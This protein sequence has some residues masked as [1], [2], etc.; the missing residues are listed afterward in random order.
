MA[1]IDATIPLGV[2]TPDP[3]TSLSSLLNVAKGAQDLKTGAQNLQIGA[4]TLQQNQ[5]KTQ[6]GAIDLQERQGLQQVLADPAN[7]TNDDGSY[8]PQKAQAN[9]MRVAPTIGTKAIEG[10]AI[11]HQQATQAQ[12]FLGQLKDENRARV[13]QAIYSTLDAPP[14]V[15]GKTLDTIG[16]QYKDI[17]GQE[18]AQNAKSHYQQVLKDQGPDAAKKFLAQTAAAVLPQNTQQTMNTPDGAP[19]DAG[20]VSYQVNTKPGV[21]GMPVGSVIPGT[22]VQKGLPPTQPTV[23][24]NNQPGIVGPHGTPPAAGH[25]PVA[26]VQ[27]D[28][29]RATIFQQELAKAQDRLANPQ[30]YMAPV[31]LQHDPNGEQFRARA[32]QDI[33][34]IQKEMQRTG[35]QTAAPRANFVPTGPVPGANESKAGTVKVI[36]DHWN[37][38][39]QQAENSQLLEGVLGN[40]KALAPGAITG[41]ESGRK[42]Y[43]TGLLNSMHLGG[44]ATG[45]MQKDTDLLEKN[46]AQL[47]LNTPATTD[48]MRTIVGAARP[49]STMSK[50]AIEEASAQIMGQIQANRAVRN[51]LTAPKQI[52][53]QTGNTDTYQQVKQHIEEVADPRAWQFQALSPE[54]RK[55]MLSKLSPEDRAGLRTKIEALHNMGLLQ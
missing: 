21:A 35:V 13:G 47:G 14:E 29:D 17:G 3:M 52:A 10:L 45:D 26:G 30:K 33:A 49:H 51:A 2:K 4:Q 19:V 20:N 23:G 22:S 54:G 31:D 15:V 36:N 50:G 42:A 38:L 5:Q 46:I 48:A 41:T 1:G 12:R 44:Q 32:Q 55:A 9:I 18:V 11:A 53:D 6:Q 8:S 39:N 28:N 40:I 37:N 25:V 24:P 34:A 43:L 27:P 16:E 7:Y